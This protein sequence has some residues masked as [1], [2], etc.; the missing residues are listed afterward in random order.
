MTID[1]GVQTDR[2][3]DHRQRLA[4]TRSPARPAPTRSTAG[5]GNDTIVGFVGADTV[6]GGAGD[7]HDHAGGDVGR[8]NA[9]TD[10]EI[11]NVEAIDAS[12]ATGPAV[13]IDLGAR[14]SGGFTVTGSAY[15][16]TI[17]GSPSS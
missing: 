2:L 6:D 15:A 4:R 7:R 9:A 11:V 5:A 13:T 1:L 16:D 10:G 8:S 3:H 12:S 17:T 14:P